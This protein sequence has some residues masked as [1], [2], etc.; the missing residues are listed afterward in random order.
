MKRKILVIDPNTQHSESIKEYFELTTKAQVYV[1]SCEKEA[2]ELIE[3]VEDISL[4]ILDPHYKYN[5]NGPIL[6]TFNNL[7]RIAS[8][9]NIQIIIYT[10]LEEKQI[11]LFEFSDVRYYQKPY[12]LEKFSE[13]ILN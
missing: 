8:E 7:Q 9:R 4:I 11:H 3:E 1:E 6:W 12:C 13:E 2:I 10:S 5:Y